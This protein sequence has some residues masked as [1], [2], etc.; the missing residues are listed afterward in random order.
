MEQSLEIQ[1]IESLEK[2]LAEIE[3]LT[4]P[5]RGKETKSVI[6]ESYRLAR[7]S[8]IEAYYAGCL[9]R[10]VKA[11]LEHG[12]FRQWLDNNGINRETARRFMKLADLQMTQ[13]VSFDTVSAALKALKPNPHLKHLSAYREHEAAYQE[14]VRGWARESWHLGES[15]TKVVE[16][17]GEHE[18]NEFIKEND[19]LDRDLAVAARDIYE[20]HSLEGITE[21]P[22]EE[23]EALVVL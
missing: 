2:R 17:G 9:L 10:S 6:S 4:I 19:N 1:E 18:L 21:L 12:N 13:I 22:I 5:E 20:R 23:L 8:V 15:L 16:L 7:R 11:D 3:T 14:S